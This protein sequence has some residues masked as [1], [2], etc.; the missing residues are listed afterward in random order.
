MMPSSNAGGGIS[1][2]GGTPRPRTQEPAHSSSKPGSLASEAKEVATE[3]AMK[4]K[5]VIASRLSEQTE[6]SAGAL[7][8]VA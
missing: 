1:N 3:A 4:A 5:D 6:K 8:D 2:V 7:A